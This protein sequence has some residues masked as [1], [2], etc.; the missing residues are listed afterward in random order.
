M[1]ERFVCAFR[2]FFFFFWH[3]RERFHSGTP[4]YFAKS[5]QNLSHSIAIYFDFITTFQIDS[6]ELSLPTAERR[7]TIEKVIIDFDANHWTDTLVC[8]LYE[9]PS[10]EFMSSI[11]FINKNKTIEICLGIF[12]ISKHVIIHESNAKTHLYSISMKVA[13]SI[14]FIAITLCYFVV[15]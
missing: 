6:L 1:K 3:S 8:E 2:C 9:M 11:H 12:V 14:I 13:D 5:W 15:P 4:F 10:L 7:K